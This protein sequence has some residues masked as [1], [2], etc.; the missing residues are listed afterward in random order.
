MAGR[1]SGHSALWPPAPRL[2]C[3]HS[4]SWPPAPR[5]VCGHSALW[6]PAPRG[7]R[8]GDVRAE[9]PNR[10]WARKLRMCVRLVQTMVHARRGLRPK[11]WPP[12]DVKVLKGPSNTY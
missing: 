4:A 8:S 3:G 1:A 9:R 7:H 6:P 12:S 5:L 11:R 10:V 2:D